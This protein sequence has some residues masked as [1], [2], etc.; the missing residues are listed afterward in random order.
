MKNYLFPYRYKLL[1]L[2]LFLIGLVLLLLSFFEIYL[3]DWEIPFPYITYEALF[4]DR[5][6]FV[7]KDLSLGVILPIIIYI[8]GGLLYGFSEE[9]QEDELISVVRKNSLVWAVYVNHIVLIL[10]L[11]FVGGFDFFGVIIISSFSLL[12]VFIIRFQ[13]KKYQLKT[14]S[15]EE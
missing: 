4:A 10:M 3:P 2:F 5:E 8:A 13:W 11:L 7:I 14:A 12:L 6:F 15:D 1:G 9:S